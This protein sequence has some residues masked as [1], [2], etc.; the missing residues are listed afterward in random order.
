[1]VLNYKELMEK[2]KEVIVF[3][4]A[5][6]VLE[7][8]AQTM[9]PP[10]ATHMR[11]RQ[12]ALLSK[13][14]HKMLTSHEI[15]ELIE[16]ILRNPEFESLSL[17][18]KRNVYLSKKAFGEQSSLPEKLVAQTEKQKIIAN[19]AWEKAKKAK[20]F[21]IFKSEL[22]KLFKLRKEAA[23]ILMKVKGVDTS[24]DALIDVFEPK[25]TAKAIA[26]FFSQL[27]MGL[28]KILRK[29]ES[30][31]IKPERSFLKR[32]IPVETQRKISKELA[33]FIGYDVESKDAGGR[34]DESEHPFTKGYYNDVRI[35]I[36]YDENNWIRCVFSLLHEG[37]HGIYDQNLRA[38]WIYQPIGSPCSYGFHESQSRFL[39]NIVGRSREFWKYFL[40]KLNK[41]TNNAF[42][43]V[44]L[45]SFVLG[46]NRVRPS[47]IRVDA[48]EV[49][50]CLH[51]IIR[52][53]IEKGLFKDEISVSELPAVWSQKYEEYLGLEI[54]HDSEGVLQDVHWSL[55]LFGYFPSYA[56]GNIYSGQILNAI[57]KEMPGWKVDIANGDFRRVKKWLTRKIYHYG[58]LYDP[59]DLIE[60]VTGEKIN[61]EPFLNYLNKKYSNLYLP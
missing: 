52:F 59:Q 16:E 47:K 51:I 7:W 29:C 10:R 60:R 34:I 49:T 23:E 8:D 31:S 48:D 22:E 54:K 56:L 15:G 2:I 19:K 25:M 5:K 13:I 12:L 18:Q 38:E 42:S 27:K 44:D 26:N 39:E 32:R 53:E 41:I 33:R 21:S 61:V 6:A 1:M 24:Y 40:P 3:Q 36:R 35:T 46:I 45:D 30:S 58:N 17:E 37:G 4:S 57:E 11:S 14:E 20:K 43:D 28:I 9:M 55:G 50:Y